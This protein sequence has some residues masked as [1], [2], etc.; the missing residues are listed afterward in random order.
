MISLAIAKRLDQATRPK[1]PQQKATEA[2]MQKVA[3][4]NNGPLCARLITS[5]VPFSGVD[6]NGKLVISTV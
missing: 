6:S 4:R 3:K 1:S 5:I 2:A